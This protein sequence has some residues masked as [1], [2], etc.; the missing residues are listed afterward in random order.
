[1]PQSQRLSRVPPE[2]RHPVPPPREHSATRAGRRIQR[3]DVTLDTRV[4]QQGDRRSLP[5]RVRQQRL[6]VHL[7]R[8]EPTGQR[9]LGG[10]ARAGGIL[11]RRHRAVEQAVQLP[12]IRRGPRQSIRANLAGRLRRQ[13]QLGDHLRPRRHAVPR[14]RKL[15][16]GDQDDQSWADCAPACG[17]VPT[18]SGPHAAG[19]GDRRDGD[20]LLRLAAIQQGLR[21]GHCRPSAAAGSSGARRSGRGL[22][23]PGWGRGRRLPGRRTSA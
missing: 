5:R 19:S 9:S 8:R 18:H 14:A 20:P 1:M 22:C 12:T 23:A 10:G 3:P 21:Q 13:I 17:E 7:Q 11:R 4:I 6:D 2:R 16:R 15:G